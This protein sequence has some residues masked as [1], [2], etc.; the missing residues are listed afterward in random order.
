LGAPRI[1]DAGRSDR[2]D[3]ET[4]TT[5]PLTAVVEY[6]AMTV[7]TPTELRAILVIL[8]AG[9]TDTRT[10]KWEKLVGE[11]ELLSLAFHPG[12]NWRIAL[13]G[14]GE[15]QKVLTAA[16]ELLQREHPYVTAKKD[17]GG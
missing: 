17:P 6:S 3:K 12:R 2:Q 15:D 9:A 4:S 14:A 16:V 8:V 7:P 13:S 11:V 5:Q 10:S 1:L